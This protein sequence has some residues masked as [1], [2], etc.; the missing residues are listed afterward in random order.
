MTL[1]ADVALEIPAPKYMVR[2]MS[3]KP[4]FRRPLDRKQGK[5][6][7]TLLQSEYQH[8]YNIY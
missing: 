3:K 5:W 8:H 6:V 7:E 2:E 1:E 4:C